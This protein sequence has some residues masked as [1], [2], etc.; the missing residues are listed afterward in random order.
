M[1][2]AV[3]DEPEHTKLRPLSGRGVLDMVFRERVPGDTENVF[4]VSFCRISGALVPDECHIG[5]SSV[6]A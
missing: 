4:S 3:W 5:S 1:L 2:F 6:S